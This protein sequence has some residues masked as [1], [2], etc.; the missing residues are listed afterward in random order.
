MAKGYWIARVDVNKPDD[1]PNY[2][3]TAKAA[4]EKYGAHFLA[5]GGRCNAVEGKGRQ[6]NVVIEFASYEQALA[7]YRSPEYQ[8][9]VPIRQAAAESEL[10]IVEGAE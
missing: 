5:R 8:K 7:C 9:A 3:A 1:Y 10:I 4:F 6:P 2:V